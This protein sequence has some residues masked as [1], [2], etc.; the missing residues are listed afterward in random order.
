MQLH[1]AHAVMSDKKAQDFLIDA[2]LGPK[3]FSLDGDTDGAAPEKD[4][5]VLSIEAEGAVPV[6][7]INRS[8]KTLD[9][10]SRGSLYARLDDWFQSL[11]KPS[12]KDKATF[13]R[14]LE[15]MINAGVPLI[16]SLETIAEQTT[17]VTM[18]RMLFDIARGIEK[19]STFSDAQKRFKDFFADAEIGMVRAAEASGQ[20]NVIL[21]DL[22][23]DVEMQE[24]LRR[25]IK[26]ALM[27]PAFVMT[28][29]LG[30]VAGLMIWVVPKI[31]SIFTESG[32]A[33]PMIT[34]GVIAV[35]NFFVNYWLVALIAI[36]SLVA[37]ALLYR[38][39]QQGRY[40]FDWLSVHLPMFGPIVKKGL[41][42]R[43]SRIL[44]NLLKSGVPITHSLEICASSIGNAVYGARIDMI[45]ED[46]ARGI[47]LGESLRD[48]PEFP[49]MVVQM[50]SVG[51][52]TA[53]LDT[54]AAKIA[55]VY[56]D[57]VD[58]AVGGLTKVLEPLL[59]VMLGVIVGTVVIAIML[60]IFELSNLAG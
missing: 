53:Q 40:F 10:K 49:P 13:F 14:L 37:G 34:V 36:G 6:A 57:E 25:K 31:S 41:L 3:S 55:E 35:S 1:A 54:M 52:Q 56:E 9:A 5:I 44:S 2:Q 43:F 28:V 18:R 38:R 23:R 12:T 46:I 7:V 45:G 48:T 59:I 21:R 8:K 16:K 51:E 26:G 42:A 58:T 32:R 39:T 11:G 4:A 17:N 19:G 60:P 33:L 24:S 15:I 50:V 30:V 29:M 22:A 20:L 47:P 27:Y